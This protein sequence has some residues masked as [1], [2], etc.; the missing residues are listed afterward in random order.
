[1]EISV[2]GQWKPVSSSNP[3]PV[4]GAAGTAI[5][6]QVGIDQTTPGTTNGIVENASAATGGVPS[7]ARLASS[8]GSTNATNV[9]TSAGRVYQA[10]VRNNA[11][12]DVFLVLYDSAA[13]PPVPGST[14]I[15]RKVCIPASSN[16]IIDWPLGLS[17]ATGIGYAFT[18][19]VADA[20]TTVIAAAD[21]TAF[22]LD[23]A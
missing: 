5:I 23:Y 8:A 4:T 17:F 11:G 10:D 2:S 12:Y 15:R 13:N 16:K 18:K 14:T 7:T 21:I 20:D 19:L 9:K 3:V 6:G 1:M 22:N